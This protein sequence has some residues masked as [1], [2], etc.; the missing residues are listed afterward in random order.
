LP[1]TSTKGSPR[2][3]RRF[4]LRS[5]KRS[6]ASPAAV[7]VPVLERLVAVVDAVLAG[8]VPEALVRLPEPVA[9]QVLERLSVVPHAVA[10][11]VEEILVLVPAA[12]LVG[13]HE[14]LRR[15]VDAVVAPGVRERLARGRRGDGEHALDRALAVRPHADERGAAVVL[16]RAGD[17]LGRARAALVHEDDQR[18]ARTGRALG[19]MELL[20][21]GEVRVRALPVDDELVAREEDVGHLARGL[22]PAPGVPAEVE[23]EAADAL[24]ALEA[25][26]LVLE[27]AR[28]VATEGGQP[29]VPDAAGED[30]RLRARDGD[31]GALQ[32]DLARLRPS[33][34]VDEDLDLG[35]GDATEALDDLL[36]G[37]T[38][39]VPAV[40]AQ[41]LVS[42][43]Q[44]L[45]VRGPPE[46]RA[47][48][49]EEVVLVEVHVGAD[50]AVRR[51]EALVPGRALL[52][53]EELRVGVDPLGPQQPAGGPLQELHVVE[54][55]LPDVTPLQEHPDLGEH[56]ERRDAEGRAA[57][58]LLGFLARRLLL[59]DADRLP[60]EL[61]EEGPAQTPSL[62]RLVLELLE[63]P[64]GG[65]HVAHLGQGE[66]AECAEIG[67]RRSQHRPELRLGALQLRQLP[68]GLRLRHAEHRLVD[69]GVEGLQEELLVLVL[70]PRAQELV[71]RTPDRDVAF[72]VAGEGPDRREACPGLVEE[73]ERVGE[74]EPGAIRGGLEGLPDRPDGAVAQTAETAR[75][76]PDAGERGGGHVRH[77][78][79]HLGADL[80]GVG[81]I[82][83]RPTG[84][85]GGQK[86]RDE[87]EE[88]QTGDGPHGVAFHV[89]R[90]H[91]SGRNL[92]TV[93]GASSGGQVLSRKPGRLLRLGMSGP[94]SGSARRRP[95]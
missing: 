91:G 83:L 94:G 85:G 67:V 43:L 51:V 22:E 35:P 23:D 58:R 24:V 75:I 17:D 88:K 80:G 49:G 20:A 27:L 18:V 6:P 3:Y 78:L 65:E 10:V 44:L 63:D 48:D 47:Y 32:A 5:P 15:I 21:E 38:G 77:E 74:A 14:G 57:A 84:S 55:L 39:R 54:V 64:A 81:P 37:L 66:S 46:D 40:D 42:R 25:S 89:D 2:S 4:R 31:L 61:L 53:G 50:A 79:L 86:E 93:C 19:G 52:G 62:R 13:V 7:G 41:H 73:Q 9:V 33:L 92:R 60:A 90:R 34:A 28:R 12:V 82:L 1:F 29:D 71:R 8:G 69:V 11:Q 70:A 45:A 95:L 16:E 30:L 26:A 76:G 87:G 59:A 68:E 72:P 56:V 36:L